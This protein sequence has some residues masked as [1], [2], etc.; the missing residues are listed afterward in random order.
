VISEYTR[1]AFSS[2]RGFDL[3]L[4]GTLVILIVIF[5]PNGLV[6]LFKRKKPKVLTPLEM[7]G[8]T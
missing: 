3:F 4:Y 2:I 8:K 6:S 1:A 7:E 5:L